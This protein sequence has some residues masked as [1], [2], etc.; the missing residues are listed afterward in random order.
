MLSMIVAKFSPF[1]NAKFRYLHNL[2]FRTRH[3]FQQNLYFGVSKLVKLEIVA[4]RCL[5]FCYCI[6]IPFGFRT[7]NREKVPKTEKVPR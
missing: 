1:E 2:D 7:I 3:D 5:D 4:S 6:E